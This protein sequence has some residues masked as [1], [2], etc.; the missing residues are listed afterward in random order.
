M[1][2]FDT[3]FNGLKLIE[4]ILFKDERG[5]FFKNFNVDLKNS[6]MP[7]P[8]E[9]YF[10]KSVKGAIRGLHF[11]RGQFAQAKLVFCVSGSFI[12]LAT[13]LRRDSRTFG[14]TFTTKLDANM[15]QGIF[16]PVGFA[17]GICSLED[18]TEMVALSSAQHSPCD[19]G[20]V[21]WSSLGVT[22][23]IERPIVSLKDSALPGI[24]SYVSNQSLC[25]D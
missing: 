1:K 10:S 19:E 5:I 21:L 2:F 12:D 25:F 15:G 13:D 11:Q 23:P 7:Y 17:H 24:D 6:L 3:S 9:S 4:G 16:L 18:N 8:V 14:K 22:L 20:G